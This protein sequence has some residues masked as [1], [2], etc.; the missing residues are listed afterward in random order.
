MAQEIFIDANIFLEIFLEDS[1]SEKCKNYLKSLQEQGAIA[2]TTDFIVYSC[3]LIV[4]NKAKEAKLIRNSI[5]FF[6]SFQ[7]LRIIRPSI[8]EIYNAVEVMEVNNL[9]FDDSLAVACMKK[10]GIKEILSMDRHFDRMKEIKRIG[11]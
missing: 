10:H 5:I 4:Q 8:G 11:V 3:I 2:L 9:D 6:N 7:N 1:K